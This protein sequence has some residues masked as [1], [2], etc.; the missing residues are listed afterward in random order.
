MNVI[1]GKKRRNRS[2]AAASGR[3]RH[4][5]RAA[6][7]QVNGA[8]GVARPASLLSI[9]VSLELVYRVLHATIY[10]RTEGFVSQLRYLCFH[11]L[12]ILCA[13]RRRPEIGTA[14]PDF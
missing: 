8:H 5:V 6:L 1:L 13:F 14:V 11:L 9:P 7:L 10:R 2:N 3:T 12:K 4:S